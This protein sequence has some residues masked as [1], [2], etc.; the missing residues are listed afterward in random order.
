M[1]TGAKYKY[2][3]LC[4]DPKDSGFELLSCSGCSKKFHASCVGLREHVRLAKYTCTLCETHGA[5]SSKKKGASAADERIKRIKEAHSYLDHA[6][7]SWVKEHLES[8]KPFA[9]GPTLDRMAVARRAKVASIDPSGTFADPLVSPTWLTNAQLRN[10]QT[11]GV[12]TLCSWFIRGVGGILADEMGLGKT[13]QTLSFIASCKHK[14]GL[15]GPHLVV[16]PTSVLL[17]WG[18]E[19]KRYT[20]SLTFIKLHGQIKERERIFNLEDVQDGKFD[21][22]LTT[23]DVLKI[24][25]A[26]F[27]DSFPWASITLDEGHRIKDAN[28]TI[29]G[30]LDRLR[31]PFRLILTGTPIQNNMLELW[32]LLNFIL[33]GLFHESKKFDEVG[34]SS[35]LSA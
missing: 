25:E 4:R 2:C 24:E 30:V 26:F 18:N 29:R 19:M 5:V 35:V 22:Y 3:A 12:S 16:V 6:K 10:Y 1:P 23:Y 27:T 20:P 34:A 13:I 17:N 28:S 14:L 7:A 21:V 33:P 9:D 8:L 15:S 31:C 11:A 32:A